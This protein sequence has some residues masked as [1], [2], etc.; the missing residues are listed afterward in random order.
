M[1]SEVSYFRRRASE[2][3]QCGLMTLAAPAR[4]AHLT[5]A[6]HLESLAR[7][8]QAT[9]RRSQFYDVNAGRHE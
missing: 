5:M 3:R 7:A 9:E 1:E 4:Q 8:I 2:E 6:E